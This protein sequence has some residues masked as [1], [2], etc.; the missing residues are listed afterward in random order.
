MSELREIKKRLA[1]LT[2]Q[3]TAQ[4]KEQTKLNKLLKSVRFLSTKKKLIKMSKRLRR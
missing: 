4:K 2:K 1:D 3:V